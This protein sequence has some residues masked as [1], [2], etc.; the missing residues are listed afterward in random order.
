MS[1]EAGRGHIDQQTRRGF[2]HTSGA[3]CMDDAVPRWAPR[4]KKEGRKLIRKPRQQGDGD[5]L[6]GFYCV[7]NGLRFALAP[8]KGLSAEHEGQIWRSLIRYADRIWR[9]A[10]LFLEGTSVYQL[11]GLARRAA[12]RASKLTGTKVT[13]KLL[14]KT[15]ITA[16][17]CKLDRVINYLAARGH[18]AIV[19][20]IEG[21]HVSHWSVI[22][23]VSPKSIWLLD[24]SGYHRFMLTKCRLLTHS[25]TKLEPRYWLKL[26]GV[27]VTTNRKK[28]ARA[29]SRTVARSKTHD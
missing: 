14:P 22:R 4:Y 6:C 24:S 13:F 15:V 19:A 28:G 18:T 16:N 9:F 10:S 25:K 21:R 5:S 3:L 17:R 20:G 12:H 29:P 2:S 1:I 11:I 7:I 23:G 8:H 26:Y 27:F